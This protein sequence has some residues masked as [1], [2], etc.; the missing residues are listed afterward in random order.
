MVTFHV[1]YINYTTGDLP[2]MN[3][4]WQNTWFEVIVIWINKYQKIT[5]LFY[6]CEK[7]HWNNST[8]HD[9]RDISLSPMS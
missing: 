5:L 8:T 6:R 7:S 1:F 3:Y 4:M 2:L 9:D